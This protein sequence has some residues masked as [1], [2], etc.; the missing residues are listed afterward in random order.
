M[1]NTMSNLDQ[2]KLSGLVVGAV[3]SVAGHG[4]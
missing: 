4:R 2:Q 3:L 1:R